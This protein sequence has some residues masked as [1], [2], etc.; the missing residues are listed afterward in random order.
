MNRIPN[1]TM[2]ATCALLDCEPTTVKL[3]A[4]ALRVRVAKQLDIPLEVAGC[5]R[6]EAQSL[7]T[8]IDELEVDALAGSDRAFASLGSM[9]DVLDALQEIVADFQ[10]GSN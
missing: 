3:V 4:Q 6:P 5:E 1:M 7:G 8:L 2:A 9:H 10:R